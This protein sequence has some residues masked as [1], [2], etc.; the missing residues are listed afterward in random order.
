M[1]CV[2]FDKGLFLKNRTTLVKNAP[3]GPRIRRSGVSLVTLS[4]L[5]VR[6]WFKSLQSLTAYARMS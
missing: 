4:C 2:Q 5:G 6:F 1:R 3:S